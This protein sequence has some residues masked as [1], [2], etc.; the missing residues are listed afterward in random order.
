MTDMVQARLSER[1][2]IGPR[3]GRLERATRPLQ[4]EA[5]AAQ[6]IN[7]LCTYAFVHALTVFLF[8]GDGE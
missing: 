1:S 7:H 3:F 8:E 5:S 6:L 4:S 2:K